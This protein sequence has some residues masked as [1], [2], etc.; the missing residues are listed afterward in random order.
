MKAPLLLQHI[1]LVLL[2]PHGLC[3]AGGAP[4]GNFAALLAQMRARGVLP[5]PSGDAPHG[6]HHRAAAQKEVKNVTA[7]EAFCQY[8]RNA[9]VLASEL[10]ERL[11]RMAKTDGG[12]QHPRLHSLL[13]PEG[14][15]EPHKC[16]LVSNSGVLLNHKYGSEIDSA[17]LVI[18]FN[19]APAGGS[20]LVDYVGSRDDIRLLNND[21][22]ASLKNIEKGVPGSPSALYVLPRIVEHPGL[23]LQ[24]RLNG[25][26]IEQSSNAKFMVPAREAH[27]ELHIVPGH[28]DMQTLSNQ[29]MSDIFG[30]VSKPHFRWD[31]KLTT[32]FYGIMYAMA[33]CDEVY[34]YG[35]VTSPGAASA[36]YHYYG[37]MKKGSANDKQ[38]HETYD[39]E[40]ELWRMVAKN[41]HDAA[42]T[43]RSVMSG[44][45]ALHCQLIASEL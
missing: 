1:L 17:D 42:D 5:R 22:A 43:D 25:T 24:E 40:K 7:E 41:S 18:R 8:M 34:A 16:A 10:Q 45:H 14:R 15:I 4:P 19:D 39:Q 36:P 9:S 20:D 11:E 26:R 44:F 32:G 2:L 13:T 35:F 27:P 23:L 37:T 33:L 30:R 6:H 3:S 12:A 38:T 29:I 31:R 28:Q 21:L